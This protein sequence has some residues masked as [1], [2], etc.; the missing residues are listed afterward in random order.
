MAIIPQS[1]RVLVERLP[2]YVDFLTSEGF[3]IYQQTTTSLTPQQAATL[4]ARTQDE[5][6]TAHTPVA[7]LLL[8]REEPYAA[9]N[10]LRPQLDIVY[11][12]ADRQAAMQDIR[13]FFATD[14]DEE[15]EGEEEEQQQPPL[16]AR[17][18]TPPPTITAEPPPPPPKVDTTAPTPRPSEPTPTQEDSP[19]P[20]PPQDPE[21]VTKAEDPPEAELLPPPPSA[22]FEAP[23]PSSPLPDPPAVD[24]P[25]PPPPAQE[26]EAEKE[27]TEES[28]P[29][30][31]AHFQWEEI[32][33][34]QVQ[35]PPSSPSPL[36]SSPSPPLTPVAFHPAP[37]SLI[38]S[39]IYHDTTPAQP[40]VEPLTPLT[41]HNYLS[42]IA[43]P[44]TATLSTPAHL[45]RSQTSPTPSLPSHPPP[46]APTTIDS[47]LA[48][49]DSK[50]ASLTSTSPLPSSP[51][52][53]LPLASASPQ[54]P[55]TKGPSDLL[56]LPSRLSIK[57]RL[58]ALNLS[59]TST[60]TTTPLPPREP[61]QRAEVD[62]GRR[63][64]L[65]EKQDRLNDL[66][67]R[68]RS[69]PGKGG[70]K[71]GGRPRLASI[72]ALGVGS[73]GV[74]EKGSDEWTEGLPTSAE[75]LA[76]EC[77]V[78]GVVHHMTGDEEEWGVRYAILH[79]DSL[80]LL[81]TPEPTSPCAL[82]LL[83]STPTT[84]IAYAEGVIEVRGEHNR[85]LFA[86]EMEDIE[87]WHAAM[88]QAKLTYAVEERSEGGGGEEE[89]GAGGESRGRGGMKESPQAS[90]LAAALMGRSPLASHHSLS[91]SRVSD[92][93]P[94]PTV[95][96]E[97]RLMKASKGV[98]GVAAA[99]PASP[100]PDAECK[101][102]TGHSSP[103][104]LSIQPTTTPAAI[105]AP[106]SIPPASPAPVEDAAWLRS[107]LLQGAEFR[108]YKHRRA[109]VRWVWCSPALDRLYWGEVK[110]RKVKGFLM[111]V[112]MCSVAGGCAGVKRVEC[113]M[114][115]IGRERTLELEAADEEQ[116]TQWIRAIALLINL[117]ANN[118]K[119]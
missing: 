22:P 84:H 10:R 14:S 4:F 31:P 25:A 42:P 1:L 52:P 73:P 80:Y 95:E 85:H 67:T 79:L 94:P 92:D 108:K 82:M 72:A 101:V 47:P 114:T 55:T 41:P 28:A 104:L 64:S 24:D 103:V 91:V 26:A 46:P 13:A 48:T 12:S 96:E 77:A 74:R 66:F 75:L 110:G 2:A 16:P 21:P 117:N 99:R 39:P 90:A 27:E 37:E 116:K 107:L 9:F 68:R 3:G 53:T 69:M 32:E 54:P 62:E 76:Q 86:A 36:P 8:E 63:A 35:L 118:S 81:T 19:T 119:A 106:T 23:T 45:L 87:R 49:P 102:G 105:P 34:T 78:H 29:A 15:E 59:D 43:P 57:E 17:I 40:V 100:L 38:S 115:V 89:G 97:I 30:V 7:V 88:N 109:K 60:P 6:F 20:H 58:A 83:V 65:K 51:S 11:G 70:A 111:G 98:A 56:S 33:P 50:R 18:S 112:D 113:G 71:G 93:S 5:L 44:N 61:V